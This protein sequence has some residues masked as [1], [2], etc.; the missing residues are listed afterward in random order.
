MC[1]VAQTSVLY[2]M[3]RHPEIRV[4]SEVTTMTDKRLRPVPTRLTRDQLLVFLHD[5]GVPIGRSTLVKL[6]SPCIG[7][8]PP[9]VAWWG[10]RPL[11]DPEQAL[12]W[13][14]ARMR[15][16]GPPGRA[17]GIIDRSSIDSC[18]NGRR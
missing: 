13:A 14:E 17:S 16:A 12:A 4:A 6:C 3:G 8:G 10:R 5:N 7:G 15:T 2:L 11:Y 18:S 1:A 9:V